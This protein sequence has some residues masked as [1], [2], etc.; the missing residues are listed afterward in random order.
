MKNRNFLGQK[1]KK[2]LT[3]G[4]LAGQS[5]KKELADMLSWKSSYFLPGALGFADP[6]QLSNETS[7]A[8]REEQVKPKNDHQNRCNGNTEMWKSEKR[9]LSRMSGNSISPFYNPQSIDEPIIDS[10]PLTALQPIPVRQF[11]VR[12]STT[13]IEPIALSVHWQKKRETLKKINP[14][15]TYIVIVNDENLPNYEN[16]IG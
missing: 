6:R 8:I 3:A 11:Q 12:S 2:G 7:T 1:N 16:E 9:K 13:G 4:D 10:P 14:R 15:L 5:A